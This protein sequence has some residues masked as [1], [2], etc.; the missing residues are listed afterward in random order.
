MKRLQVW[1]IFGGIA[2]CFWKPPLR[3]MGLVPENWWEPWNPLVDHH[4]MEKWACS[5]GE[6]SPG[7]WYT[8]PSA[9]YE[10]V[11]WD[12]YSIPNWMESQSKFHGSSHHLNQW[13][14][15]II[16]YHVPSLSHTKPMFQSPPTS[17]P[18]FRHNLPGPDVESRISSER[19]VWDHFHARNRGKTR[20]DFQENIIWDDPMGIFNKIYGGVGFG[21]GSTRIGDV[22]PWRFWS[23]FSFKWLVGHV[24]RRVVRSLVPHGELGRAFVTRRAIWMGPGDLFRGLP[25]G[26]LSLPWKRTIFNQANHPAWPCSIVIP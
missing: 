21:T 3:T 24:S 4:P 9:K 26:K 8:Y 18:I 25:S 5:K 2:L 12:D 16:N 6:T 11:S 23:I 13:L 15:T 7:W 22:F 20:A 1:M 14:L 10:F 17:P 19:W